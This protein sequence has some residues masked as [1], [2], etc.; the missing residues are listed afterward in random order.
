MKLLL[1]FFLF[2]HC[3]TYKQQQ[4]SKPTYFNIRLIS[5]CSTNRQFIVAFDKI[6]LNEKYYIQNPNISGPLRVVMI[7]TFPLYFLL[8]ISIRHFPKI[9][10]KECFPLSF[11]Q[12]D[13][14]SPLSL[15]KSLGKVAII[16]FP[17]F[18]LVSFVY[19]P[20]R[21]NYVYHKNIYTDEY[22]CI[23]IGLLQKLFT[24]FFY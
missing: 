3:F 9:V 5:I 16:I 18:S 14:I 1:F 11:L 23:P 2:R 13:S 17:L 8:R 7:I 22:S 10:L 4:A 6:K 19:V 12:P 21:S 24:I 15:I 20:L